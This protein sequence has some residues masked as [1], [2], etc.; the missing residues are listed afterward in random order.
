MSNLI[1]TTVAFLEANLFKIVLIIALSAIFYFIYYL[2]TFSL[3]K[4]KIEAFQSYPFN[5]FFPSGGAWS[6]GYFILI[7]LLLSFLI[8]FE[9]KGGF[10]LGP[11]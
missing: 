4:L 7:I 8:F 2:S 3:K 5:L 9:L 10:Y 1:A 6:V 11:A